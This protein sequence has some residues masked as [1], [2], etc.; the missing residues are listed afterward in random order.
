MID[1]WSSLIEVWS[2]AFALLC[3]VG[4]VIFIPGFA[5]L[6]KWATYCDGEV[7]WSG[8]HRLCLGNSDNPNVAEGVAGICLTA[9]GGTLVF[10]R[11]VYVQIRRYQ[12]K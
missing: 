7:K 9:I 2:A 11:L 6:M 5:V 3:V 8:K 12:N 1:A 10:Q 4:F